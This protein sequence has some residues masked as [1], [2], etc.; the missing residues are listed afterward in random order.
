MKK[1]KLKSLVKSTRKAERKKIKS[2]IFLQLKA[3]AHK[4][5]PLSKRIERVIKKDARELAKIISMELKIDK[6][7]LVAAYGQPKDKG[8]N[9][10]KAESQTTAADFTE[11]TKVDQSDVTLSGAKKRK[12]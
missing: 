10:P 2:N 1:Q 6:A 4:L 11:S 8:S 12:N 7:A 9:T 3:E 5:V